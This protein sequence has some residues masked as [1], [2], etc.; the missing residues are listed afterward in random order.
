M[1]GVLREGPGRADGC[2]ARLT[3]GRVAVG[4]QTAEY[5]VADDEAVGEDVSAV[6]C[7]QQ[8]ELADGEADGEAR[9][10]GSNEKMT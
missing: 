6:V 5:A 7:H 1:R 4:A 8:V 9:I 2:A 3:C 10:H